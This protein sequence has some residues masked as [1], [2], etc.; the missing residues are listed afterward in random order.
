MISPKV[1]LQL[2]DPLDVHNHGPMNANEP[3]WSQMS[4]QMRHRF[5]LTMT[6]LADVDLNVISFGLDPVDVRN[7][8]DRCAAS[9]LDDEALEI[10]RAVWAGG[11]V[12]GILQQRA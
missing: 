10:C 6:R 1:R 8:E 3:A 7:V 9:R 2:L 5:T 12:A 11:Q 4:L